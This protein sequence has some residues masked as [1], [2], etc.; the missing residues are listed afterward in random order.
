M[1]HVRLVAHSA[2]SVVGLPNSRQIIGRRR[3]VP[4][5]AATQAAKKFRP[6][7]KACIPVSPS[8]LGRF[9]PGRTPVNG[10]GDWTP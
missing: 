1:G 10:W 6:G 8:A 4:E 5:G 2:Q 9:V 3:R 7:V